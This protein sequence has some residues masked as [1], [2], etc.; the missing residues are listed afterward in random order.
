MIN[1][2]NGFLNEFQPFILMVALIFGIIAAWLQFAELLPVI[3]QVW[4]PKGSAQSH[5]IV[6]ACLAIIAGRR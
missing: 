4:S 3:K 5:A 1:R 2:I 6:A